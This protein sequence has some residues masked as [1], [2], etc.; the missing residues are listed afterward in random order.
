MEAPDQMK[1]SMFGPVQRRLFL[2][3][4]SLMVA[5]RVV[6]LLPSELDFRD[7]AFRDLGSFQHVDRLI[8]QGLR[9]GMDFGFTYGLLGVLLQHLYIA[10]FGAGHWPTLGLLLIYLLLMLTFWNLLCREIGQSLTNFGVLL[11]LSGIMMYIAPWPPT[12]AHV[13]LELS[14]AFSLY[15]LLKRRFSLALFV[16]AL[17]ALAIPSLPI[18]L[19]GLLTLAIAWEWWQ[20]PARTVRGLVTQLAPAAVGYAGVVALMMAFFGRRPVL[21]SLVPLSGAR[22]YR[23]MNFGF[24]GRGRNLWGPPHPHLSHYLFTPAGIW[25]FCSGLLVVFGCVGAL[26]IGRTGKLAG[27]SFFVVICCALHLVFVFAAFGNSLSYVYYSFFLCAGVL[28]GVSDLTNRR[29]RI[30]VS[31]LLLGLGLLSQL[32]GINGGLKLWKSGSV[33]PATA[34]LYAPNDFQPEWKSVLSLAR[35]RRV[36]LL[37]YGTGVDFYYPKIGTAQSWILLPGLIV[38]REDSFVLQQIRMADVVV[39]ELEVATL[40][41]DGNKE[42]QAALGDFHVK[43]AGRYFRIWTN[44]RADRAE[45]LKTTTFRSN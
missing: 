20:A 38:A 14:L 17:G 7:F 34:S 11:G 13:L 37:A 28:A 45:L 40:Y 41:I 8:G 18:V 30:A 29:L 5:L 10:F 6:F 42:W 16:A 25:L 9:P 44:D 15:F 19:A 43:V 2:I 4:L 21:L 24:F 12:P 32:S 26:R 33:S 3:G 36:F 23:A 22:L 27:R 39:E 1:N 35:K 31:S